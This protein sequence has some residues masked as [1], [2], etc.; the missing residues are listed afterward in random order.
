MTKTPKNS[1]AVHTLRTKPIQR[2]IKK[3]ASETKHA[4][5]QKEA[6]LRT[7]KE[8]MR[9]NRQFSQIER[10]PEPLPKDSEIRLFRQ[11]QA[12]ERIRPAT[13][14]LAKQGKRISQTDA[15][16][17]FRKQDSE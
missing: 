2:I 15:F 16:L 4:R 9:V 6:S 5:R 11:T 10:D 7:R 13:K 3:E 12:I 17:T 8:S 1:N 14:K